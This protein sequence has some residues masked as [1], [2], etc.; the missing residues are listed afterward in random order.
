MEV[1]RKVLTPEQIESFWKD[2]VIC[3]RQLYTEDWVTRIRAF[4]DDIVSRPSPITGP[5]DPSSKFHSDVNT[6]LTN[7]EVRDL[8]LYGPGASVAQQ[9]FQSDRVIFYYDQIFV[10]EQ[11]APAPTPWHHDFTFWPLEGNQIASLWASVDPVDAES[12]ALEFVIGSHRWPQRFRAIGADGSDF[13]TGETLEEVPDIDAD[14]SKFDIVSWELEPGDALLFHALTLHGARGNRS[15][16]KKRR[17][18]ATRWCGDDVVYRPGKAME[19][20]RH[21][22]KDG[23]PFSAP[24]YPQVYPGLIPEQICARLAGPVFPDPEILRTTLQRASRLNRV[25]LRPD[26]AVIKLQASRPVDPA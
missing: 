23:E 6:W 8:V 11:L 5:R 3:I 17:A 24:V 16:H 10:K 15:V 18:I 14:R 19:F 9:V 26:P 7:D 1:Q 21:D 13:S 25:E 20:Y 22:L 4:L 12:S 2:G